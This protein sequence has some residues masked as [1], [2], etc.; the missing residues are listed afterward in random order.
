MLVHAPDPSDAILF[1]STFPY[2]EARARGVL[3][4]HDVILMAW[5]LNQPLHQIKDKRFIFHSFWPQFVPRFYP[6]YFQ[7]AGKIEDMLANVLWL[8][9]LFAWSDDVAGNQR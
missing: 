7:K 8:L 5:L 1:D 9:S 2:L 4:R 3:G 6:Y